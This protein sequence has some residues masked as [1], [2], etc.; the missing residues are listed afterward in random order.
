M[1]R[2][3]RLGFGRHLKAS[4]SHAGGA[5]AGY[6]GKRR[7]R[8]NGMVNVGVECRCRPLGIFFHHTFGEVGGAQ[9]PDK[10]GRTFED[11]MA[12]TVLLFDF[13]LTTMHANSRRYSPHMSATRADIFYCASVSLPRLLY[14][15]L[16]LFHKCFDYQSMI[17]SQLMSLSPISGNT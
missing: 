13:V 17:S 9:L 7:E 15:V 6:A 1:H 12:A 10:A 5:F 16:S 14:L 2:L 3:G 4:L 11:T 8:K